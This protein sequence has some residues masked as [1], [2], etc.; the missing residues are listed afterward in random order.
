MGRFNADGSLDNAFKAG[1]TGEVFSQAFDGSGRKLIG[2]H[3]LGL[4]GSS[5]LGR[6]DQNDV[7]DASFNPGSGV[8]FSLAVQ[9]D[10]RILAG[11]YFSSLAGQSRTNFGRLSPD[12]GLDSSFNPTGLVYEIECF[13][14]Q[15]DGKI[16][17]GTTVNGMVGLMTNLV[18]F[19]SQGT[20]DTDFNPAPDSAVYALAV[21]TDGKIILGGVFHSLGGQTRM[22]LG[23]INADGSLDTNFVPI[24]YQTVYSLALQDD[25]KILIGGKLV[26]GSG[27]TNNYIGRLQNNSPATQSLTYVGSTITW[28]RGGSSPEAWRTSF[29]NSTDGS[30]WTDLGNGT[31]ISGG[32][33]LT[34][35]LV[36]PG[37]LIRARGRVSA[38]QFNGTSWFLESRLQVPTAPKI[39]VDNGNF[40]LRSNQFGFDFSGPTNSQIV[41]ESSL[42]L[43]NWTPLA[44]NTMQSSST[45]FSEPATNSMAF[46]RLRLLP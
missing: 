39:I 38:G 43:F 7:P 25:G 19:D 16:L 12:G 36:Q 34:G 28:L 22:G 3:L 5:S 24:A 4:G 26:D 6:L 13:A 11:G 35:V 37:S 40:G 1:T 21:Q 8:L 46:Y 32:W 9:S 44:T 18:R 42:D 2:G 41:V 27:Q 20:L 10:D 23:R 14:G 15:A 29:Q 31:R 33:Q 30:V 17:A 45:Y